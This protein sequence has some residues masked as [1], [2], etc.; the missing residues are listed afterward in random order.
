MI[1][2][3][4]KKIFIAED[5]ED[6]LDLFATVAKQLVPEAEIVSATDGIYLFENLRDQTPPL[7]D[8]IFLD[9]NMPKMDGYECLKRIK[10]DAA[11]KHIPIIILSTSVLP[12]DIDYMHNLGAACYM[13]KQNT[14]SQFKLKLEEALDSSC[15]NQERTAQSFLIH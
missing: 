13:K 15:I 1:A 10:E 5:D 6:D 14:F 12:K 7:P 11:W 2:E 9:I 4:I 3:N 8:V